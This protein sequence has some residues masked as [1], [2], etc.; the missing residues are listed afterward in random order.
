MLRGPTVARIRAVTDPPPARVHL[1]QHL[2]RHST[3]EATMNGTRFDRLTLALGARHG[4][5]HIG[6]LLLGWGLGGSLATRGESAA[7]KKPC[8]ACRTRK[9]GTCK[10]KQPDGTPCENGSAC[11]N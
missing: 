8:P 4:R 10:G 6:L 3:A 1:S 9:K 11:L 7:K 5:R 2:H